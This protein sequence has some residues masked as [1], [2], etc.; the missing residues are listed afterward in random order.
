MIA[1]YLLRLRYYYQPLS[2]LITPFVRNVLLG[3]L[4]FLGIFSL[5]SN[6]MGDSRVKLKILRRI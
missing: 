2:A 1:I 4:L 3:I 5:I 6:I